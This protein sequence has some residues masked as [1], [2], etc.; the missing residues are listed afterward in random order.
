MYLTNYVFRYITMW[1]YI[2]KQ[3]YLTKMEYFIVVKP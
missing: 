3:M 1:R 2:F